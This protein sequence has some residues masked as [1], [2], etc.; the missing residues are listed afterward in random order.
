MFGGRGRLKSQGKIYEGL[1][2]MNM[3]EGKGHEQWTDGKF[4][5]G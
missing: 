5:E 2:H 3:R 4:F 1:W